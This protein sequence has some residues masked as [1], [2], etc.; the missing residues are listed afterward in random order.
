VL[1]LFRGS[2]VGRFDSAPRSLHSP[3]A[4]DASDTVGVG[5]SFGPNDPLWLG[6]MANIATLLEI[7]PPYDTVQTLDTCL[8]ALYAL[9]DLRRVIA[10]D[11]A[12][13]LTG[14]TWYIYWVVSLYT[15]QCNGF[16]KAVQTIADLQEHILQLQVER[17]DHL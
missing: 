11:L 15:E 3:S 14:A 10:D 5:S 16:V 17:G 6:Q 8:R 1:P 9:Q 13:R 2:G 4:G 12:G 7:V